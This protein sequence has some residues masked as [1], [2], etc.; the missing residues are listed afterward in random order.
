MHFFQEYGMETAFN[1]TPQ[2]HQ[3]QNLN[4]TPQQFQS[5]GLLFSPLMELETKI[6]EELMKNPVLELESPENGS[7]EETEESDLPDGSYPDEDDLMQPVS[8]Y[9]MD[10]NREDYEEYLDHV[11]DTPPPGEGDE[12][13]TRRDHLFES[14]AVEI[15]LQDH[16]LDQLRFVETSPSV[17]AC[18]EYVIGSLDEHGYFK[19]GTIADAAQSVGCD[20]QDA[21]EALTLVQSFE[22]AG[23]AARDLQ[24]C[25]LLQVR[26]GKKGRHFLEMLI[27]EHLDDLAHNRL[28]KIAEEMD[29]TM[30]RLNRLVAELR[31]LDPHPGSTAASP[32]LMY[33]LP[34]VT[35]VPDGNS[36]RLEEI[37]PSCGRLTISRSYQKMLENPAL[38][39]ED[40]AYLRSHIKNGKAL[41]HSLELRQSTIMRIAEQILNVQFDFMKYGPRALRP[42]TM[43]EV[44]DKLGFNE[45]TISRAVA[46][47][48]IQ[49]PVGLYEFRFFFSSGFVSEEGEE[50]SAHAVKDLIRSFVDAED[51]AH[52][53]SDSKL[54]AMLKERGLDVARRTVAKYRE[55]LSIQS[56]QMRKTF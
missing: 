54:A 17:F 44:A 49:T 37:R 22:P 56:S 3:E 53:L 24:E 13:R 30:D 12:E 9:V 7:E 6:N 4:L 14:I 10:A 23:I 39:A 15:S 43:R 8:D 55:E 46:G 18:A 36:F 42:M 34:E 19:E 32:D 1:I 29:I 47:K 51:T 20:L 2:Q 50:I 35:V 25:L 5:L 52:P 41:I 16:L 11:L 26:R 38:A 48:Y 33:I 21:E 28:P 45:A 31:M 40:K 27:R